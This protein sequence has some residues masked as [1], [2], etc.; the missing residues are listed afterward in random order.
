MQPPIDRN[1]NVVNTALTM[2]QQKGGASFS[3]LPSS[4]RWLV[5]SLNLVVFI[6]EPFFGRH[7]ENSV[8]HI[9]QQ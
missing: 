7:K 9:K 1:I 5:Y 8:G 6:V 3:V 4:N 2:G